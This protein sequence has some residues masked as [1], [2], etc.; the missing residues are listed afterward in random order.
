MRG[1]KCGDYGGQLPKIQGWE[2]AHRFSEQIAFCLWRNERMSNSVKRTS[3]LLIR[4]FLV[5]DLGYSLTIAHF[6]W[7]SWANRSWCLFLVSNLGHLL[8]V[9][10]FSWATWAI[11]SHRSLKKRDWANHSLKPFF[12][13][14]KKHDFIHIFFVSELSK[15]LIVAHFWWA[16]WAI[17]SQSL[18]F[19]SDLRDLLT[20][21]FKKQRLSESLIKKTL[22]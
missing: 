8:T 21:L 4:S 6:W 13:T 16:T 12:K 19:M 11:R 10:L 1:L 14:Y 15:S 17:C 3:D 2:F 9:T 20:S 22:F 18:F 7:V 5:I